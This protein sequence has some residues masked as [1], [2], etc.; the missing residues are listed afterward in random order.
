MMTDSQAIKIKG[1]ILARTSRDAEVALPQWEKLIGSI[2]DFS[3]NSSGVVAISGKDGSGR[4]TFMNRLSDA[5]RLS[6]DVIKLTPATPVNAPGWLLDAV[7]PW[8]TSNHGDLSTIQKKLARL[9][10]DERPLLICVDGADFIPVSYLAND[11]GAFLNLCDNCGVRAIIVIIATP[12]HC[13]ALSAEKSVS[14]K[15]I[16]NQALPSFTP[17]QILDLLLQK[18][19]LISGEFP[20][21]KI[22]DLE[23]IAG[24]SGGS[25]TTASRKLLSFMG[26]GGTGEP[27]SGQE[28]RQTGVNPGKHGGTRQK[29]DAADINYDLEDLLP[30]QHQKKKQQ[31]P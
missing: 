1:A 26:L 17:N 20:T 25:P 18:T 30:K 7:A 19:K 22:H 27:Q 13:L 6:T 24:H 12:E 23:T 15:I 29:R 2:I 3:S 8:L 16:H 4:T 28:I 10:G 9:S 11:I 31:K 5:A 14:G 21:P